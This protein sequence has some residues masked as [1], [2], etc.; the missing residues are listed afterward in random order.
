MRAWLTRCSFYCLQVN[1][2]GRTTKAGPDGNPTN[3]EA[4]EIKFHVGDDAKG[5]PCKTG[6]LSFVHAC[7]AN[8]KKC[9]AKLSVFKGAVV[10]CTHA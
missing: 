7:A 5:K 1:C 6:Q 3:W 2:Q 4:T 8:C 10:R 9:G